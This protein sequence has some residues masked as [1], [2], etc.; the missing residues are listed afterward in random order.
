MATLEGR[1]GR[2]AVVAALGLGACTLPPGSGTALTTAG[3]EY[4][5]ASARTDGQI[6]VVTRIGPLGAPQVAALSGAFVA[7][8]VDGPEPPEKPV[9]QVATLSQPGQFLENRSLVAAFFSSAGAWLANEGPVQISGAPPYSVAFSAPEGVIQAHVYGYAATD[10]TGGLRSWAATKQAFDTAAT[11]AVSL[12][13]AQRIPVW[14]DD[15]T[16]GNQTFQGTTQPGQF[17]VLMFPGKA[18][19][20]YRVHVKPTDSGPLMTAYGNGPLWDWTSSSWQSFGTAADM[21][22]SYSAP[23]ADVW[24]FV[25]IRNN[26]SAA[27]KWQAYAEPNRTKSIAFTLK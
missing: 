16:L 6:E 12:T 26:A 14:V 9:R 18:G 11:T 8:G 13:A 24:F 27:A 7:I 3:P 4:L 22:I 20:P 10:G 23:T 25:N 17:D 2:T 5:R 21:V 1:I 19:V 15:A